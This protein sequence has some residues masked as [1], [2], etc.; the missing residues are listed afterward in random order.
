MGTGYSPGV[1]RP[2]QGV[3]HPP[4]T[5]AEVKKKDRP[6][7]LLSLLAF[8]AF[9]TLNFTFTLLVV[10]PLQNV[11]WFS[12]EEFVNLKYVNKDNNAKDV[13]IQYC[14]MILLL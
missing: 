3:D 13:Y 5:S 6:L 9:S 11:V 14:Y 12:V 2:Q 1:K 10:L 4:P 8:V 7:P